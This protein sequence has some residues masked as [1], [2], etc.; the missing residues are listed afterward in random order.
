MRRVAVPEFAYLSLHVSVYRV[1]SVAQGESI[2]LVP[3]AHFA[4]ACKD[5]TGPLPPCRSQLAC[6][7]G[8]PLRRLALTFAACS[9]RVVLFLLLCFVNDVQAGLTEGKLAEVIANSL[10]GRTVLNCESRSCVAG[11]AS[12]C[13]SKDAALL[14]ARETIAALKDLGLIVDVGTVGYFVT[15]TRLNPFIY[16]D[17]M[18]LIC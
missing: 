8:R 16:L 5:L 10:Y 9:V 15:S 2:L 11:A 14:C 12:A 17:Y 4:R 6:E 7:A 1:V 18:F 13:A 3:A